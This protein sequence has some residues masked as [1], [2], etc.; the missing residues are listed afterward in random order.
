MNA[1]QCSKSVRLHRGQRRTDQ[2]QTKKKETPEEAE[3]GWVQIRDIN[4]PRIHKLM[5]RYIAL[6][7]H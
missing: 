1:K 4:D 5:L 2:K 7:L 3:G 6:R